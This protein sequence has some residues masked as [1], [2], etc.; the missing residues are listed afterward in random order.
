[1]SRAA[2]VSLIGVILIG[3]SGITACEFDVAIGHLPSEIGVVPVENEMIDVLFVVDN[4]NSMLEEHEELALSVY[5]PACPIADINNVDAV[6][7]NPSSELLRQLQRNC[8]FAQ[9][10]AAF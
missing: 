3:T 2:A 7:R 8:G 5:N 6:F 4:S 10:L 1:M 9:I